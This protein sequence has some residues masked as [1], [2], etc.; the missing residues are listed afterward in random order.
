MDQS[1]A[2]IRIEKLKE[3]IKDLNYK[4]FVL[5]Q[6]EVSES[7]RDSLK[8]ELIDL[9]TQF[10]QFITPD[11]PTQRVGSPLSGR[12]KELSHKSPK[13]SL[14]DVFSA[15]EI[16]EWAER[17]QKLVSGPLEF[18]CELKI[19]G[20][21]ITIQYEKGL[22]V[23]ALTRGDGKTGEDVTHTVKTIESI[24]LKL[25]EEIDLE[26]S[27]EV[28]LPKKSFE[29]LNLAQAANDLPPFANPR[30]A[31]AGSVRQ[32][33]PQVSAGRKLDMFC[34]H[35]DRN[36][37][38]ES[39][40]TQ[41][42]V[43]KS[44]KHLGL[45]ICDYYKKFSNIDDVISFCDK[46]HKKREALPFEIDGIVIKVNDIEQQKQMGFTAKAPRF[47]VAYKFP[48]AQVSSKILDI[49][50]Q[51]GRTGAVTP[52]AVMTPTLVAGSTVS[53]AT[54]HNEDEIRKK[55]IRIG[56]TVIIQKAGDVIPEVVEVIKDLR[57]G[58]EKIFHFPKECPICGSLIERK[59]DESAYHCTNKNCYAREKEG[60]IHFVSK[61]GFDMDGLGEKIV[62]QLLEAG[63]I[64]DAADIFLL[65][66]EDVMSLDLFKEKRTTNLFTSIEKAKTIALERFLFAL[67]I[68]YLGEQSSY[69][70]A[71]QIAARRSENGH[72]G[73]NMTVTDLIEIV[74]T[75]DGE[76]LKNIDGIG[77]KIGETLYEWFQDEKNQQYL[78]KLARASIILTTHSLKST[79]SLAGKSF[80][81][82]GTLVD[83]TRDQAKDLIKQKGGKIH[84]SISKD[85]DYLVVGES[86]GSKLKK[87]EELGV[88]TLT[89]AEFKKILG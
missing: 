44:L 33:D 58:A 82:T 61:K 43:L 86:A 55:D 73:A 15:D 9:E 32:L 23:R 27:G 10:P 26:V 64:R 84:S 11:S 77:E 79:G 49:I 14:A 2:K 45:R 56:D 8:R 12:F 83:L 7:V 50:L 78:E 60:I 24:P 46:W 57:T 51:I 68:R 65:K 81:L 85:T 70:F 6:S 52:V 3:K 25:N 40:K 48:A 53:R 5:D 31:A 76:S 69:D 16:K 88:K 41:E 59:G 75:F 20:L 1:E 4:Y 63:L 28:Y 71:R 18:V 30:N 39:I 34:Y 89:E 87:A 47:A 54:L 36:T 37:L 29:E 80:V 62:N 74:K 38:H 42:D 17:I 66:P 67:G 35:I 22:F 72:A 21:N 19:D 13:M